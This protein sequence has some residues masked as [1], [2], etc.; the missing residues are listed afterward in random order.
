[1]TDAKTILSDSAHALEAERP[2][3][4]KDLLAP[5]LLAQ[6][7]LAEARFLLARA[8]AALGHADAAQAAFDA[9]LNGA[10]MAG[11]IWLELALFAH[12][13]G[14]GDT[15]IRRAR[16]AG[17]PAPLL[18]MVTDAAAGRGARAQGAGDV[19]RKAV[20]ALARAVNTRDARAA[21]RAEAA[22]K[23]TPGPQTIGLIG[24]AR[25]LRGAAAE[26]E[27]AFR[28]GLKQVPPAADLRLGLARALARQGKTIPALAEARRAALAAPAWPE[29]QLTFAR[30]ALANGLADHALAA[31]DAA[32]AQ[33]PKSDA[34]RIL[35]VEAALA[36]N[37]A[38]DAVTHADALRPGAP[39]RATLLARAL[40]AAKRSDAA[41]AAWDA[42]GDAPAARTARAQLLQS[43]GRTEAAEAALRDILTATPTHGRAARALA[44]G[45]RLAADDPAIDM[46]RT[47]LPTAD[48]ENRRLLHYA[49]ARA[50]ERH[51]PDDAADH[52]DRANAAT[53]ARWPHDAAADRADLARVIG[54]EWAALRAAAVSDG[55]AAPIFVT[56]LPRSGTT[57]VETI[58]AAHGHVAQGGE[59]G[60]LRR[61]LRPLRQSLAEGRPPGPEALSDAAEA[62]AQAAA[63][64]AGGP[65]PTLR[66][67]D[68]S[69]HSFVQLGAITKVL[70][71][72]SIVIVH[73]D[74]RDTGLSIWRNDFA[75]GQHRYAATWEGIADH[76]A[77]FDEALE[78]WRGALP[79]GSF[80]EI[81]YEA[82]LADPEAETRRLIAACDLPWDDACLSFHET[83]GRVDTLSFAQVRRPIYTTSKGGWQSAGT[84][85]EPLIAALHDR[86]LID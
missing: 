60:V 26:A 47:A 31:A 52:L 82:L 51:A 2:K 19:P 36:C 74:P 24:Q 58:L 45:T 48:D 37:R 70:P 43:L 44:Y 10:P 34:A 62:Y 53:A 71:R 76:I 22:I 32:L 83:A 30:L 79:R 8:E 42:A 85:V 84:Q 73:R 61:A 81:E 39:D 41:L 50:L 57:L 28:T 15:V 23:G 56:G 40:T 77:L 86:G 33:A 38:T 21:A 25:L 59:L 66:L 1:M 17:L 69:I 80:H 29:A 35:A 20:Q 46:M 14:H 16:A 7:D 13:Q 67:T 5:L 18:I 6:P 64:A 78:F 9:A 75:D 72:A 11:A 49:L 63:Q 3:A 68:K 54:V 27:A 4:A 55:T 65:D 12:G